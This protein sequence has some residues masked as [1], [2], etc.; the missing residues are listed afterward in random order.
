[1]DGVSD[2]EVEEPSSN[3]IQVDYIHLRVNTYGDDRNLL[4]PPL[5]LSLPAVDK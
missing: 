2:W 1:M 5:S 4:L 3:S